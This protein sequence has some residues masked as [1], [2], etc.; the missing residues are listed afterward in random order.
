MLR[1]FSLETVA[2]MA[3]E[4]LRLYDRATGFVTT[5]PWDLAPEQEKEPTYAGVVAHIGML[6]SGEE[7]D[8]KRN[9]EFWREAKERQGWK[10]GETKSEVLKT[11]PN[12]RPYEE[13]SPHQRFKDCLFGSVVKTFWFADNMQGIFP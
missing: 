13:L 9:H 2:M 3:Y 7:A 5:P 10:Y 12:I 4:A 11:H 8:P 6:N 1:N